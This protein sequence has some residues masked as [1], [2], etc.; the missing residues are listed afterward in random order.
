MKSFDG[1]FHDGAELDGRYRLLEVLGRGGFGVVYKA[2][3]LATGQPVAVKVLKV[4]I[5]C[6]GP[7][8]AEVARFE[9]E[10]KAVARLAHPSIVKLVDSGILEGRFRYIVLE[11]V[12]GDPLAR[13][14]D[15]QGPLPPREALRLMRQVAEALGFA[16]RQGV[17]HRDLKPGN[18]M[19]TDAGPRCNAT[20]LDFGII[21]LMEEAR[22]DDYRTLTGKGEIAGTPSY[23]APEQL[24]ED[25]VGPA[26]D[27]YTWGLVFIEALT[28]RRAVQE[29]SLAA[30]VL[31]YRDR[32]RMAH[33][34]DLVRASPL[35][36]VLEKATAV[37]PRARYA[38]IDA[39]LADLD[40]LEGGPVAT[41][42]SVGAV[43]PRG[44]ELR[45]S[46]A[47]AGAASG[48]LLAILGWWVAH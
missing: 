1:L 15:R 42:G 27:I 31:K 19:V 44:F 30:L 11:F 10:M 26:T 33:V 45:L 29:R 39:L 13:L 23:M 20:V 38:S 14:L 6:E 21:H 18:I 24:L 25:K 22:G 12:R 17:V 35:G 34:P 4:P 40:D 7:A 28:G 43:A 2:E 8:P 48:A 16:H 36:R 32:E 3:Q 37:E 5:Q 41:S 47:L 46:W 9:R